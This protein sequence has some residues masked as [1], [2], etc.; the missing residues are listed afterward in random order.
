MFSE[1]KC[2]ETDPGAGTDRPGGAVRRVRQVF[3]ILPK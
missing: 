2:F 3:I 1:I